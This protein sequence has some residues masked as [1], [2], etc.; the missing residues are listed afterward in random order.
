MKKFLI[1]IVQTLRRFYWWIARPTTRGV[2]AIVV[3]R[4]GGILLV[5]H[6]YTEGWFLPGGKVNR[7]EEDGKALER[8]LREEL[9]IFVT[10]LPKKLGE[11][12]N[13]VEYKKDAIAVFI[14]DEF[15]KQSKNHFEIEAHKFFDPWLLPEGTSPGTRRRVQEWLGTSTINELW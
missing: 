15:T 11:Y 9:G 14:I 4:A 12:L 3:N 7:N 13:F 10:S 1:R 2:R 8:E 5:K 6:T